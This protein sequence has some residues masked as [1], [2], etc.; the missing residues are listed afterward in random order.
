MSVCTLGKTELNSMYQ[1]SIA[2]T[3]QKREL[4]QETETLRDPLSVLGNIA[5]GGGEFRLQ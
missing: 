5:I 3:Q 2:R 4:E 1:A